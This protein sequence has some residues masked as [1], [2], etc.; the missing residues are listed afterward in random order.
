MTK[1]FAV[2]LVATLFATHAMM[3]VGAEY[4]GV[5]PCQWVVTIS[6]HAKTIGGRASPMSY[7]VLSEPRCVPDVS[8]ESLAS[9]IAAADTLDLGVGLVSVVP[10]D[11][12]DRRLSDLT[13]GCLKELLARA[14]SGHEPPWPP[15]SCK[16]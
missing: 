11:L 7:D 1:S 5:V 15:E 4:T 13:L 6:V 9:V 8:H 10:G 12:D 3:A 14:V 16:R 2:G